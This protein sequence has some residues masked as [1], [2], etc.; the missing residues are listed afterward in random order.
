MRLLAAAAAYWMAAL[1][2][3]F[4]F[5]AIRQF[6]LTPWAGP[7]W[8]TLIELPLIL[9]AL[10][11]ACGWIIRRTGL[12]QGAPRLA[13]GGLWLLVLLATEFVLGASLRGWSAAETLAHFRTSQGAL[14]L[15]GFTVATLFP[16]LSRS[17]L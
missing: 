17:S 9:S 12:P 14:G 1:V 7:V 5:G 11:F 16:R 2:C 15:V 3:G 10:W 6:A 8:A 13:M 4:A